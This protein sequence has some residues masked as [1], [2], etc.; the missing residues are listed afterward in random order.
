MR[1]FVTIC[2]I[3]T[4]SLTAFSQGQLICDDAITIECNFSNGQSF[5]YYGS[6]VGGTNSI[7]SHDCVNFSSSGPDQK[8]VIPFWYGFDVST[9]TVELKDMDEDLDL[10]IGYGCNTDC[11]DY[12]INEGTSDE[13]VTIEVSNG[14]GSIWVFIDGYDGAESN[15]TLEI[16]SNC[17]DIYNTWEVTCGNQNAVDWQCSTGTLNGSLDFAQYWPLPAQKEVYE[18]ANGTSYSFPALEDVYAFSASTAG[19]IN[20]SLNEYSDHE[21]FLFECV[22]AHVF[23]PVS[24]FFYWIE[25]PVCIAGGGQSIQYNAPSPGSYYLVVDAPVTGGYYELNIYTP[26]CPELACDCNPVWGE[27]IRCEKFENYPVNNGIVNDFWYWN[28][29]Y[30][31]SPTDA[32]VTTNN[33]RT[34]L[35]SLEISESN[36]SDVALDLGKPDQGLYRLEWWMSASNSALVELYHE[37]DP[38][39]SDNNNLAA[40]L[41]FNGNG[42]GNLYIGSQGSVASFNYPVGPYFLCVFLIDNYG[43]HAECWI[44]GMRVYEWNF[45]AS[46]SSIPSLEIDAIDF[47]HNNGTYDVDDIC[48]SRVDCDYPYPVLCSDNYDPVCVAGEE[49]TNQCHARCLGYTEYEWE[50]GSCNP[51][52]SDCGNCFWYHHD[53]D[54]NSKIYFQNEYCTETGPYYATETNE[55]SRNISYV[56]EITD[57]EGNQATVNYLEGTNANSANPVCYFPVPGTYTVCQSVFASVDDPL[58]DEQVFYCCLEITILPSPCS[59]SPVPHLAASGINGTFSFQ[60]QA[61][62]ADNVHY[63]W[64]FPAEAY[65]I[66]TNGNLASCQL[67]EGCYTVCVYVT[68][69]CGVSS[70]CVS[71]CS[72]SNEC[73]PAPGFTPT[74]API[75]NAQ[76]VSFHGVPADADEYTWEIPT[77][78]ADFISGSSSSNDP[79]IEFFGTGSYHVCLTLRYGCHTICICFTVKMGCCYDPCW[80]HKPAPGWWDYTV[81]ENETSFSVNTSTNQEYAIEWDFGDGSQGFGL[82]PNHTYGGAGSYLVCCT[83]TNYFGCSYT[84]CKWIYVPGVPCQPGDFPVSG[85]DFTV[86]GNTISFNN[87]SIGGDSYTW[88]FGDGSEGSTDPDPSHTYQAPGEYVV[89]LT[90]VNEC[91]MSTCCYVI[92]IGQ[93][94]PYAFFEIDIEV[95]SNEDGVLFSGIPSNYQEVSIDYGNGETAFFNGGSIPDYIYPT[96]GVYLVCITIE[97]ECYSFTFCKTILINFCNIPPPMCAYTYTISQTEPGTVHFTNASSN[98]SAYSW[99]FGDSSPDVDAEDPIHQFN[100]GTYTVC[101]TAT[102]DCAS[103]TYCQTIVI[104]EVSNS[105]P[106]T[107]PPATSKTHTII[108]P[109]TILSDIDGLS[110]AEGDQVSVWYTHNGTEKLG[111]LINFA[112]TGS[113]ISAYG[114]DESGSDKNG[115]DE[116]EFFRFRVWKQNLD[117]VFEVSAEFEPAG[118]PLVTHT[119]HFATNGISQLKSLTAQTTAEIRIPLSRGWNI[120]SSNVIPE[121]SDMVDVFSSIKEKTIIVKDSEGKVYIPSLNLNAISDW[122]VR[123]GYQVKVTENVELVIRGT[124]VDP[125]Q[126]PV[127]MSKTWQII[128]YL[129][130]APSRMADELGSISAN[131]ILVKNGPDIYIPGTPIG[132]NICME[133]GKGYWL[134]TTDPGNVQLSY[135]CGS[136]CPGPIQERTFE[137]EMLDLN[138]GETATLLIDPQIIGQAQEVSFI[139][140]FTK[141]GLLVGRALYRHEPAALALW[142]DDATTPFQEGACT[143]TPLRIVLSNQFGEAIEEAEFEEIEFSPN[144]IHTLQRKRSQDVP[145]FRILPNPASRKCVI[146]RYADEAGEMTRLQIYS[147]N[148][149][150]VYE[151]RMQPGQ[152]QIDIDLERLRLAPG[153]YLVRMESQGQSRTRKLLVQAR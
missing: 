35:N 31:E 59:A 149:K 49:I 132:Q 130:D 25:Q 2:C 143:G 48:F 68:N 28:Y 37:H 117:Q 102:N 84:I 153:I 12:S 114:N 1:L 3:L 23:D 136:S 81:S 64:E 86:S 38:N 126:M 93:Y 69:P 151:T 65:N 107:K 142:G 58:I 27:T 116:G 11:A 80:G 15:Y 55:H 91:G 82:N 33:P 34:G 22:L 43:D 131:T 8:L 95:N 118:G 17:A 24:G 129:C 66:D 32:N 89:C 87:T 111:G 78:E 51:T 105:S 145:E 85:Y 13:T 26:D 42:Q 21:I 40:Y 148:G 70:Y 83:I 36:N 72:Y 7:E 10:F 46:G 92:T 128:S 120:I 113:A 29:Y 47:Y 134:K 127:P 56:W 16:H 57:H 63:N 122:D 77:G 141:T 75:I 4:F 125:Q 79:I 144:S 109:G 106:W 115:F 123:Y 100:P 73:G 94:C 60:A 108:V 152:L 54:E 139:E 53:P 41:D 104:E 9:L 44:N 88:D 147:L 121:N 50:E 71:V 67:P 30:N 133:P 52:C 150:H 61:E 19:Q 5:N 140:V 96:D 18:C 97:M 119:D 14:G 99:N 112:N 20:V 103:D 135:P 98:A 146:Q 74:I 138:T 39:N 6:T 137:E 110:L 62:S 90:V 124:K 76:T 101:L 45:S